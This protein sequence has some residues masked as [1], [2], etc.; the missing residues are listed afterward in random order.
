MMR[1]LFAELMRRNVIRAAALYVGAVWALS[2]GIAQL[3]PIFGAPDWVVRW[4][5][6][7]AV[8][9]FPFWIAFAWLY[10]FTPEG[11][12]REREV[13]P[14]G[15]ITRHTGR[16]LDFAIIGVLAVSVVLLLT[17]RFVL[18]HGLDQEAAVPIPEH[19]IAVLPFANLSA[20]R[21]QE[22]FSDGIAEDLLNLLAQ[23]TDLRVAARTSSFSFK[24]QNVDVPDI[25][26]RLHVANVLEGSVRTAGER[27]R[28]TAR[29]VRADD[30]YEIWSQ[31]WDRR[32]E[33]VFAIQDEIAADV[34]RQLKIELL[35][36]TPTVRGTDSRAYSLLLQGRQIARLGGAQDHEQAIAL[37]Q[38]ALAIDNDYA[39]AWSSIAGEYIDQANKGLKP[40]DESY[41]L[42]RVAIDRALAIDPK[43][44]GAYLRRS[45][46]ASDYDNDPNA[47][48]R[49]IEYALAL[50]PANVNAI[51]AAA[52]LYENLGRLDRAAELDE[53][54]V[55]RD[56]LN[57]RSFG[58]LGYD[59][60][61]LGRI[62]ESIACYRTA[63]RLSPGRVGTAYN[64]GELLL[65]KGDAAGAL[66]QFQQEQDE[67]WRLMGRAMALHALGRKDEADAALTELIAKYET[68]SAYNIAY[69]LAFRGETDRAFAWL[70]KAVEF[71][72][73][74]IV[75][76]GT[77]PMFASIHSDPRWLPFLRSVGKAPEQLAVVEFNVALP[78]PPAQTQDST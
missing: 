33:D 3:A 19:S 22:Y 31:S 30:G 51:S 40:I 64:I 14:A 47:A 2:Q 7:A 59:Y 50:E 20:D 62:D 9:G 71:H 23:V 66:A 76:I 24:G 48:A 42:A 29:L 35:G 56:P 18:H 65:R 67:N 77:D 52:G 46:I 72:D 21:E 15:S 43:L 1:R 61:R 44:A 34:V 36:A 58:S 4:L 69:V 53:Y 49:D 12:R 8:I 38:Q 17:D 63:L 27:V 39:E 41:R 73:T 45:R 55:A 74:G 37:F 6:I 78:K 10:E 5:L 32:L 57:P 16:K 13:D 28:I 11:L 54:V 68:D 60:G 26:H 75:E 25:A 70:D